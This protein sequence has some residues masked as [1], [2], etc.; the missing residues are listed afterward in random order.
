[1]IRFDEAESLGIVEPFD[2]ACGHAVPPVNLL[3]FSGW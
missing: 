3:T 1:L 2:S